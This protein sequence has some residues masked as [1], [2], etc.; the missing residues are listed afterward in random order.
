MRGIRQR[1]AAR[2]RQ[3]YEADT[4]RY[5]QEQADLEAD[6]I[7]ARARQAEQDELAGDE[8]LEEYNQHARDEDEAYDRNYTMDWQAA[9]INERVQGPGPGYDEVDPDQEDLDWEDKA[10]WGEEHGNPRDSVLRDLR[11]DRVAGRWPEH[12]AEAT[13]M[14]RG[15]EGEWTFDDWASSRGYSDDDIVWV[16]GVE[17]HRADLR[18]D[19]LAEREGRQ[20]VSEIDAYTA[21]AQY[22]DVKDQIEDIGKY[23][24]Q[25]M[26]LGDREPGELWA[27]GES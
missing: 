17:D 18:E 11:L 7:I 27:S 1:L 2:A 10:E 16:H 23:V 5:D 22:A 24:R 12:K 26:G 8:W 13:E 19:R 9:H 14:P 3:Q 4:A 21:D 15:R 20:F 25:L 6:A